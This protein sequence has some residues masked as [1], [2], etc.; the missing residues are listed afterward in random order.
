MNELTISELDEASV[1]IFSLQCAMQVLQDR[2]EPI[3][4]EGF[5][6]LAMTFEHYIDNG[7]TLEVRYVNETSRKAAGG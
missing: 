3:T 7:A 5:I 4:A 1:R 2:E 6:D